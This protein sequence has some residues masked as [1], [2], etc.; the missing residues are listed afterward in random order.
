M[1]VYKNLLIFSIIMLFL[2]L[3]VSADTQRANGTISG[4]GNQQTIINDYDYYNKENAD[5]MNQEIDVSLT[6]SA[7]N[8]IVTLNDNSD[9]KTE[10]DTVN[11]DS[12]TTTSSTAIYN[13]LP[14]PTAVHYTLDT[15]SI[16]SEVTS[17]YMG[18][19]IV[20]QNDETNTTLQREGEHYQYTIKSSVP[21][22]AYIIQSSDSDKIRSTSGAPVF[23]EIEQKYAHSGVQVVLDR[24]RMS[25]F[26]QFTFDVE[27]DGKYALVMDTRVTQHRNGLLS[28]ISDDTVDI[29]Y[30]IDKIF[31]NSTIV[32]TT[33]KIANVSVF[34]TN[35]F[36]KANTS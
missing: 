11:S 21:L 30:S 9:G 29:Y 4:D 23:N 8:T 19:V 22:L 27:E 24:K 28:K 7:G 3:P 25:T 2:A 26:Q 31:I 16:S 15:G 13:F 35:E 5:N 10:I 18:E 1:N 32:N 12:S 6:D 20:I 36:G 17:I 33:P 34:P 14:D